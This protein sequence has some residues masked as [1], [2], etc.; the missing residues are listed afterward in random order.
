ME[1]ERA[2]QLHPYRFSEAQ[3]DHDESSTYAQLTK[4]IHGSLLYDHG[5]ETT[6][7]YNIRFSA[8]EDEWEMEW[9]KRSGFPLSE[10]EK[11]W[12]QLTPLP[13]QGNTVGGSSKTGALV[14]E[15]GLNQKITNHQAYN[16][17]KDMAH[18][19]F[20][21]F[22]PPDNS[23]PDRIIHALGRRIL[24]D[25]KLPRS[26]FN[27][28]LQALTYRQQTM[29]VATEYKNLLYLD[30]PASNDFNYEQWRANLTRGPDGAPLSPSLST[31]YA[32]YGRLRRM[33]IDQSLF[34]PPTIEQ[35]LPYGKPK[36]YLAAALQEA[37]LDDAQ[38]QEASAKM[39]SC[40]HPAF[41]IR[42]SS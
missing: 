35:G 20:A 9:R 19:Y 4:E 3:E 22:P 39:L 40:K 16:V 28:L 24:Q 23:S 21:S 12:M 2:T 36:A 1:D 30:F 10:F 15:H 34:D 18:G 17:L 13:T 41:P 38:V 25:E 32:E 5:Q 33:I 31:G 42:M 8:Q 7:R 14:S 37:D 6:D 29:K 26:E 11:R 27:E